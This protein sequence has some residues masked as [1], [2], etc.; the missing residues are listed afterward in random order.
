MLIHKGYQCS[1]FDYLGHSSVKIKLRPP[2]KSRITTKTIEG[3]MVFYAIIQHLKRFTH[4]TL[5]ATKLEYYKFYKI[6]K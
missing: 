3:R 1:H 2:R 5:K 6:R 4:T